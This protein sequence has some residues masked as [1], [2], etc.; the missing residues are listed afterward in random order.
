M[1]NNSRNIQI[2]GGDLDAVSVAPK[3]TASPLAL[4]A[5]APVFKGVGWLSEDGI[6]WEDS[7]DKATIT[8][9]QGG[10]EVVEVTTKVTREFKFQCLEETALALGL[11]YPGF[12]PAEV[13]PATTPKVYGGEVLTPV[14]DSRVW[15]IDTYSV[16]NPGDHVRKIIPKGQVTGGGAL[17]AKRGEVTVY[18]FTVKVMEGKFFIYSNA[19]GFIPAG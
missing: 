9:H 17:V 6:S 7:T 14:T 2:Y 3:G 5:L 12:V 16:S 15:V 11:R 8:A 19:P 1:P 18:E 13:L 10:V 4:E